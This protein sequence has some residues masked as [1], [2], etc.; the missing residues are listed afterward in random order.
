MGEITELAERLQR[1][2][3]VLPALCAEL[4]GFALLEAVHL[5]YDAVMCATPKHLLDDAHDAMHRLMHQH[6]LVRRPPANWGNER[7]EA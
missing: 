7:R 1:F 3:R 6:G 2:G 5:R 4:K